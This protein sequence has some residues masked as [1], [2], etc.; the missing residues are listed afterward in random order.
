MKSK[1]TVL[2]TPRHGSICNIC[3]FHSLHTLQWML[4]SFPCVLCSYLTLLPG[5]KKKKP[6]GWSCSAACVGCS[7]KSSELVVTRNKLK[8]PMFGTPASLHTH[9]T[10]PRPPHQ[11]DLHKSSRH[12]SA[13]AHCPFTGHPFS[14]PSSNSLFT[15]RSCCC[16]PDRSYYP[17]CKTERP[18][19]AGWNRTAAHITHLLN[20]KQ[21]WSLP[22]L[23]PHMW[24][25]CVQPPLMHASERVPWVRCCVGISTHTAVLAVN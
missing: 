3:Y 7:W 9:P 22:S 2:Q 25:S 15:F 6:L 11:A 1:K 19:F 14:Q 24:E 18:N 13:S 10:A 16:Y 17:S 20:A 12:A 4:T 5:W 23:I 21:A 8:S